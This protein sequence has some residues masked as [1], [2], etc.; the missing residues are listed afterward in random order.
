MLRINCVEVKKIDLGGFESI[1]TDNALVL[2]A[3]HPIEQTL[4]I[5]IT[6]HKELLSLY[7][8]FWYMTDS[9]DAEVRVEKFQNTDISASKQFTWEIRNWSGLEDRQVSEPIECGG[10]LFQLLL[11][12]NGNPASSRRGCL[13]L[14]LNALGPVTTDVE[15][16]SSDASEPASLVKKV[17][18]DVQSKPWHVCA[19]FA[20]SMYNPK[21]PDTLITMKSHHRFTPRV[22]DWGYSEFTNLRSAFVPA[23]NKKEPLIAPLENGFLGVNIRVDLDVL[24]DSTGILWHDFLD[25]NSREVTGYTGLVNQGATCYLNSL[26]QSL[27]FTSAF[28]NAVYEI[29]DSN[30][31]TGGLQRLFYKLATSNPPVDTTDLTKAFG[32]DSADAFTQHDVQELARVLMDRLEAKM[33]G[34]QVDGFL[35]KLFVGQMKSYIKCINV[36]FESSRTEDFWDVQLNV[37]N[38]KNVYSSFQN[39]CAKETLEGDN[40]YAADG[41][42]LQDAVKGVTFQSLPPVLHLQLKRYNYDWM[43]DIEVKVNDRFEF[44]LELD[45][46]EFVE[47]ADREWKY[48]LHGVL[49][50]SG[51]LNA[52]HYYA[53][54]KPE[55]KGDWFKFDDER[56]TKASL[57]EV[58][59]ENFGGHEGSPVKRVTSAYM[60]VYIRSDSLDFVLPSAQKTPPVEIS[61]KIEA[62]LRAENLRLRALAEQQQYMDVRIITEQSYKHHRGL[63]IVPCEENEF[64]EPAKLKVRLETPLTSL[65]RQIS[66]GSLWLAP[67]QPVAPNARARSQKLQ[68]VPLNPNFVAEHLAGWVGTDSPLVFAGPETSLPNGTMVFVKRFVNGQLVAGGV[69]YIDI[70]APLHKSLESNDYLYLEMTTPTHRK[71]DNLLVRLD[72]SKTGAQEIIEASD[73][74]ILAEDSSAIEQYF[75]N[76]VNRMTLLLAPV[77]DDLV[78]NDDELEEPLHTLVID[79][80]EPYDQVLEK[81]GDAVGCDPT[82]LQLQGAATKYTPP[83]VISSTGDNF[84]DL[85]SRSNSNVLQLYYRRL[86]MS[87][88]EFEKLVELPVT[89]LGNGYMAE[90]SIQ[91]LLHPPNHSAKLALADQVG[92]KAHELLVWM[93][94]HGRLAKEVG[95]ST[96]LGDL[97]KYAQKC[98]LYAAPLHPA[99]ADARSAEGASRLTCF[100]FY[101]DPSRSYGVPF[102]LALV[103]NEPFSETKTR[104]LK[105]LR[106]QAKDIDKSLEKIQFAVVGRD[107]FSA[108]VYVTDDAVVLFD[109][110]PAHSSLGL[111][112]PNPHRNHMHQQAI[113][114]D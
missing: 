18:M 46:T 39:Y 7:A 31:V 62:E 49:V 2:S 8:F 82:Q 86:P 75:E 113:H 63:G 111:D 61:E 9:W 38:M 5:V 110:L 89:W 84:P 65:C 67:S 24:E 43:R 45:L 6:W 12:P 99:E 96:F 56:V 100:H 41:Y 79:L 13:A 71:A 50:H 73:I 55:V 44:P 97:E 10:Y 94:Q 85:W 29:P 4:S 33:K 3:P 83:Q 80:R 92:M 32:W 25:Y 107:R 90:E 51:E 87:L 58:L 88:T 106:P 114:I 77:Y 34:T 93:G 40:Q 36:D 68:Q 70:D 35:S 64:E 112:H 95:S 22:T 104:I 78:Y 53:L 42:G 1:K 98:D 16:V 28:R 72:S 52:G 81:I 76:L 60:L 103:P 14:Y 66:A 105:L 19:A 108:P 47:G 91:V 102:E 20:L 54:L 59:E 69:K 74:L 23:M 15:D 48:C 109:V 37:E 27:Y 21:S 26:L 11:F 101:K 17:K 30:G 57:H